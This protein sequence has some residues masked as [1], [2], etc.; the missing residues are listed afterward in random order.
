MRRNEF[1]FKF[2]S[3][4]LREA[5]QKKEKHHLD[6]LRHYEAAFAD[7]DKEMTNTA[8]VEEMAVTGGTQ[9]V[10]RYD[11][12]LEQKVNKL[13]SKRDEHKRASE[14]FGRWAR[15][16]RSPDGYTL[17]DLDIDDVEFFGL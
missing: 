8:R 15:A 11:Q 12:G 9:R 5:A 17:F 4:D 16:L 3:T 13:R 2:S 14:V 6:R 7:A 1:R 10:L